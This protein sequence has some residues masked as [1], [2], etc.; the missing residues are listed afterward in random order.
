MSEI[1]ANIG[2]C[3]SAFSR[4]YDLQRMHKRAETNISNTLSKDLF[5]SRTISF[6]YFL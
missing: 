3:F 1:I 5:F 4:G 2:G 6:V